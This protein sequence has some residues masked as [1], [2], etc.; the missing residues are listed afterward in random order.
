M[1]HII[2]IL[3]FSSMIPCE[4]KVWNENC[5]TIA[6]Y[7]QSVSQ[8]D[9]KYTLKSWKLGKNNKACSAFTHAYNMHLCLGNFIHLQDISILLF[10]HYFSFRSQA[11]GN[12]VHAKSVWKLSEN[13]VQFR[14]SYLG[15]IDCLNSCIA[16][17]SF[18]IA[19]TNPLSTFGLT[20][21]VR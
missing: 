7:L 14:T 15:L 16:H 18:S 11:F 20:L 17:T 5:F 21:C 12:K 3:C 19:S 10:S 1:A 8:I 13:S 4:V 6:A 9:I 2:N